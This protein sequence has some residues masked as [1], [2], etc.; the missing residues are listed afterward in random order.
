MGKMDMLAKHL[1]HF[2]RR[3]VR[4]HKFIQVFLQ[5]PKIKW[6]MAIPVIQTTLILV[7]LGTYASTNEGAEGITINCITLL[8]HG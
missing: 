6:V 5:Y 3:E 7:V 8:L 4:P 2:F 1:Y